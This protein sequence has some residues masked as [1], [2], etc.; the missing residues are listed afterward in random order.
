MRYVGET[1]L[2]LAGVKVPEQIAVELETERTDYLK[3]CEED[4]RDDDDL[5]D[6]EIDE[7]VAT[8]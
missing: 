4:E 7:E 2:L 6:G 1:Q 5:E 3:F 8:E